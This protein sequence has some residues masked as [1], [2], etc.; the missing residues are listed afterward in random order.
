VSTGPADPVRDPAQALVWGLG[1]AVDLD[2]P[3]R[4]GGL[5]DLPELSTS[6]VEFAESRY[7]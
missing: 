5:A 7:N 4:W 1:R 3:D 6:L 2:R